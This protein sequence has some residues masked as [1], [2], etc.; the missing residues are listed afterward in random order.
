MIKPI[1]S[2]LLKACLIDNHV[3]LAARQ[4][5]PPAEAETPAD[6]DAADPGKWLPRRRT[7]FPEDL[8]LIR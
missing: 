3:P 7:V 2:E 1:A 4:P 5:A 8:V 6:D